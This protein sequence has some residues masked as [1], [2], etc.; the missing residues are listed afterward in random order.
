[1]DKNS[2]PVRI[3]PSDNG[4]YIVRGEVKV[5]DARGV[6]HPVRPVVA[7]CRC[8][9]SN[10]KPFCDSSHVGRFESVVRASKRG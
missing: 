5:T 1:M 4:P 8:G 2:E 9:N 3:L 6:E 7:L 10:N